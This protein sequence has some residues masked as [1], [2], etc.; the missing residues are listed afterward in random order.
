MA[1]FIAA[2]PTLTFSAPAPGQVGVAYS[3]N[4]T[5]TG[6]TA[7]LTWS[8]A[9]GSSRRSDTERR[10]RRALGHADH[11]GQ[12]G[13][14]G[15][16]ERRVRQDGDEGG[17]AGD[18]RRSAGDRQDSQRLLGR[19]RGTVGYTITFTNTGTLGYTG[20]S[21]EDPLGGVLDDATYNSNA[22]ATA[23]RSAM[24]ARP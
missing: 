16:G 10:H 9:A 8:I 11:R 23:A 4:L 21:L 3:T 5:V 24:S 20:V 22:V 14:H 6:G 2:L 19:G 18:R 13:V 15:R 17:V 12:L 7:P 1:L